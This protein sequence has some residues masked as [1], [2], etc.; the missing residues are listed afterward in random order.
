M[1]DALYE[2]VS[3]LVSDL[4]EEYAE[5]AR[6][7]VLSWREAVQLTVHAGREVAALLQGLQGLRAVDRK[8]ILRDAAEQVFDQVVGPILAVKL[9]SRW[10]LKLASSFVIP[11]ARTFWMQTAET[12]YEALANIVQVEDGT[13]SGLVGI[14]AK[15]VRFGKAS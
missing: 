11:A 7:G 14:T 15:E 13:M 3:K 8:A 1:P 12:A 4:R 5:L 9:K 10:D 2:R 6:D